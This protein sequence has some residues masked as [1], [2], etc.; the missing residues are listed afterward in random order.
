[1]RNGLLDL[2][3][4]HTSVGPAIALAR[5]RVIG[6]LRQI[7]ATKVSTPHRGIK[8]CLAIY[9]GAQVH[10]TNARKRKLV[11]TRNL[12]GQTEET[13]L[14]FTFVGEEHVDTRLNAPKS[15]GHAYP[16]CSVARPQGIGWGFPPTS[17]ACW[18]QV[19]CVR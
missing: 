10:S 17:G 18:R 3:L 4:E 15:H 5:G 2:F 8:T 14:C 19:W 1:M 6:K 9:Q 13:L 12:V 16:F 7:S 11:I